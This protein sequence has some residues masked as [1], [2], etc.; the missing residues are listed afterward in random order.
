VDS[1]A[2]PLPVPAD[3]CSAVASASAL[4]QQDAG[5]LLRATP[6]LRVLNNWGV[7]CHVEGVGLTV[8]P[9]M[10]QLLGTS[11]V[12][13]LRQRAMAAGVSA[14]VVALE[15]MAAQE[16]MAAGPLQVHVAR[17]LPDLGL[18]E[19]VAHSPEVQ[20]ALREGCYKA[21]SEFSSYRLD[22]QVGGWGGDV[23]WTCAGH[24]VCW[25]CRV[26]LPGACGGGQVVLQL[27]SHAAS[28][29]CH[30]PTAPPAPPA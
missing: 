17:V 27:Q 22:S 2:P 5:A 16:V 4:R 6:L 9:T 13:E 14:G 23:C 24:D 12:H 25:T 11:R 26:T 30:G 15:A 8:L 10:M 1:A 7:L 29:H 28:R 18:V 19:L 20:Q 3:L 21:R